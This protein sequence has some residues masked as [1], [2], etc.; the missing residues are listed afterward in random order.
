MDARLVWKEM[1]AD[2]ALENLDLVRDSG[3]QTAVVLSLFCDRRAEEDDAL[4]DNTGDRRGWWADAYTEVLGDRFGSRL[5]LLSREKQLG[6]VLERAREYAEEALAWLVEDG[7]AQSVRVTA[8]VVRQGV[9]G[10]Q[11]EITRPDASRVEYRF[12]RLWEA[13]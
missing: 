3:L 13:L 8:S 1:G 5:W 2:L 12:N 10:L 11:V 4:P 9:L 6:S 7:V